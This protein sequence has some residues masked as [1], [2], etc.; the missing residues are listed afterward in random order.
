MAETFSSQLPGY[1]DT[2]VEARAMGSPMPSLS[3]GRLLPDHTQDILE[4]PLDYCLSRLRPRGHL[5]LP[6]TH[7]LPPFC[8]LTMS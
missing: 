4:F 8:L 6:H 3:P 2:W 7:S 1:L 5:R